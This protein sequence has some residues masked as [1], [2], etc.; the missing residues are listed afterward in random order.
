MIHV[1]ILENLKFIHIF[2]T[3]STL[4]NFK[5]SSYNLQYC[6]QCPIEECS[7]LNIVQIQIT[8]YMT[9]LQHMLDVYIYIYMKSNYWLFV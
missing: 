3:V 8:V 5:K 9:V 1:K 2:F 4:K 6:L 7:M